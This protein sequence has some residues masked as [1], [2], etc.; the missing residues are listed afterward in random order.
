[1][2]KDQLDEIG[3]WSEAK[4]DI[5]RNYAGAYMT[6]LAKQSVIRRVVYIDAFAGAGVHLSRQ[7]GKP[8]LGSPAI[9]LN[10]EPPFS[11]FHFVDLDRSRAGRLTELAVG[12]PNVHVYHD[13]CN[14]I[15]LEQVF[16]RCRYDDYARGL[17]LL[18]PYKLAVDWNVL[19]AAGAM[20]SIEVFYNFMIM[21]ANMNMFLKNSEDVKP[22][23]VKRINAVWGDDSWRNAVYK[24]QRTL[25]DDVDQKRTNEDVAEAFRKRLQNVAGFKYV[26]TPVPMCN[27]TGAVV[28]YLYFASPNQTG[29]K[30]VGDIF[31]KYRKGL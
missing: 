22:A 1:M 29:A 3:P 24:K 23:E 30:I 4:L 9:A 15:L 12:R 8:V 31:S 6:V 2:A 16:P 26:P 21:D 25:F 20:G 19:A 27:S 10:I 14:D 13:D 11:E 28:Y 17:C 18:D 7:T 5:L